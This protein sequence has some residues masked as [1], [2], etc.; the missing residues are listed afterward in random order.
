MSALV[1][2]EEGHAARDIEQGL[3]QMGDRP[4]CARL[5]SDANALA[6]DIITRYALL[7]GQYD[8]YTNYG[9]RAGSG[10]REG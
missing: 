6:R 3:S 2:H 4:A 7:E 10:S 1:E 8:A 9:E 5:G